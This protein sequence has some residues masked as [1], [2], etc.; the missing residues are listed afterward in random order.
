MNEH[1]I[2]PLAKHLMVQVEG[3]LGWCT[4]TVYRTTNKGAVK[5]YAEW[6]CY[7]CKDADRVLTH[8]KVWAPRFEAGKA[9]M[10]ELHKKVAPE[11]RA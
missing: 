4:I 5:V 8:L 3:A 9:S 11:L 2:L 10:K 1:K 6:H 7:S